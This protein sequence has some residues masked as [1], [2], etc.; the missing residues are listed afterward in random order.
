VIGASQCSALESRLAEDVGRELAKSGAAVICGGLTGVMEAVCRGASE[1]GGLTIGILPG[2]R[3]ESANAFV[4]MPIVTGLGH[5]RNVII[6]KSADAAIAIGGGYGTLSE[7]AFARQRNLRVIGLNTWE[8]SR[9][10]ATDNTIMRAA[11]AK[12]AVE[13]ALSGEE[14]T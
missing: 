6:V 13:M 3:S 12:E 1:C 10:G 14:R 5:A 7:I 11:S 9:A 2:D 8:I 4:K